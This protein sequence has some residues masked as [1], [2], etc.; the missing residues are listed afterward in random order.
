MIKKVIHDFLRSP[1]ILHFN[2]CRFITDIRFQFHM[3]ETFYQVFSYAISVNIS[4]IITVN[5][6]IVI[7]LITNINNILRFLILKNNEKQCQ[8]WIYYQIKQ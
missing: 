6:M 7:L 1:F 4:T 8:M 3:V 5:I 2:I